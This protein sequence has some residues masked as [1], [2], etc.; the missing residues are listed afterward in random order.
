MVSSFNS[1]VLRWEAIVSRK[2]SSLTSAKFA[3][4]NSRWRGL[5]GGEIGVRRGDL[6]EKRTEQE[7]QEKKKSREDSS[8]RSFRERQFLG[9]GEVEV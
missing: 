3:V 6:V 8:V 7:K 4:D 5:S 2:R 1:M 9:R